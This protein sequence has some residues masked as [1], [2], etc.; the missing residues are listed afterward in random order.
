[1]TDWLAD[2]TP[3]FHFQWRFWWASNV[4][5]NTDLYL[6]HAA[7]TP[8]SPIPATIL[9][10]ETAISWHD[11]GSAASGAAGALSSEDLVS[12]TGL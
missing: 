10:H 4:S 5:C 12:V 7:R 6:T 8:W 11:D 2:V 3:C 9:Q 1:M